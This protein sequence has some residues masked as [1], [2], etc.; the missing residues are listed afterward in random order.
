MVVRVDLNQIR[1]EPTQV[2]VYPVPTIGAMEFDMTSAMNLM[3]T[4][5]QMVLMIVLMLLPVQMLP[6]VLGAIRV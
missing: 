5:M 1:A 2:R 3:M 4:M 6:K